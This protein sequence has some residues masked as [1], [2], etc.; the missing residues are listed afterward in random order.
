MGIFDFF[1]SRPQKSAQ[2]AKERLLIIVA[3][4]RGERGTP[5][6]IPRLKIELLEV[7]RKYVNVDP[8][9]VQVN[10]QKEGEQEL[11]ELSVVLPDK[12]GG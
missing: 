7:I 2:T 4:Q 11:L 12:D 10:L 3:Q 5:D 8:S 9:A 6:Y 1:K